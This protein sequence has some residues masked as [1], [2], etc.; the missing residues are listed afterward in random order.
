MKVENFKTQEGRCRW[1]LGRYHVHGP[2]QHMWMSPLFQDGLY[3]SFPNMTHI[4]LFNLGYESYCGCHGEG[5]G[6]IHLLWPLFLGLCSCWS[7]SSLSS[8]IQKCVFM[9]LLFFLWILYLSCIMPQEIL[10]D[11]KESLPCRS[12]RTCLLHCLLPTRRHVSNKALSRTVPVSQIDCTAAVLYNYNFNHNR[13]HFH[14]VLLFFHFIFLPS[15]FL[16]LFLLTFP[17]PSQ[18]TVLFILQTKNDGQK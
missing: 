14:A 7:F 5:F 16:Y 17:K 9:A 12:F 11:P 1:H 4:R 6:A 10:L 3:M 18:F 15:H 13:I 2:R 8:R